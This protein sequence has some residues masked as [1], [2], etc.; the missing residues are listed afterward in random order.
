MM[1]PCSYR[2]YNEP[3][4]SQLIA[5]LTPKLW[6]LYI[7]VP[8]RRAELRQ[9]VPGFMGWFVRRWYWAHICFLIIIF[10]FFPLYFFFWQISSTTSTSTTMATISALRL[11]MTT[12]VAFTFLEEAGAQDADA[13][14]AAQFFFSS[15]CINYYFFWQTLYSSLPDRHKNGPNN[16]LY[17]DHH[18]S[19]RYVFLCIL[20]NN[21]FIFLKFKRLQ[22][23]DNDGGWDWR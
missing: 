14:R 7:V 9:Q 11:P 2:L 6:K 19:C 15:F 8:I 17:R 22:T 20:L 23:L 18:L 5:S 16:G 21:T 3:Q 12:K 13:S 4:F 1:F 10:N